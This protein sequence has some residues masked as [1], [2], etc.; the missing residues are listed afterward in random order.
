MLRSENQVEMD[1]RQKRNLQFDPKWT[2]L[3]T[4]KEWFADFYGKDLETGMELAG[5]AGGKRRYFGAT[6]L[7]DFLWNYNN[8]QVEGTHKKARIFPVEDADRKTEWLFAKI[9]TQLSDSNRS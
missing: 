7:R 3:V 4:N 2:R 5:T 8:L 6:G 9:T 1:A